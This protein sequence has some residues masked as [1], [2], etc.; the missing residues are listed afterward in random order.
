M[1]T[2]THTR[3][4]ESTII[5][6]KLYLNDAFCHIQDTIILLRLSFVDAAVVFRWIVWFVCAFLW[7]AA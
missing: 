1:H 7:F 5:D 4:R 2:H 3:A 6:N